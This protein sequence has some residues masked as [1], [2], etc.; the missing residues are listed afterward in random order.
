MLMAVDSRQR[1]DPGF[2]PWST[3]DRV[4][5]DGGK[6]KGKIKEREQ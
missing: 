3:M 4:S 1:K 5:G 6:D 2:S